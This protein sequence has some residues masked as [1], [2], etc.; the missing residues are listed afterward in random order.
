MYLVSTYVPMYG[1]HMY[2]YTSQKLRRNSEV[3]VSF[4]WARSL[5]IGGTFLGTSRTRQRPRQ[6]EPANRSF[7]TEHIPTYKANLAQ[8]TYVTREVPF[9]S[10]S[11]MLLAPACSNK[12][13]S[14][15]LA[16][17]RSQD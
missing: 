17:L 5:S 3:C 12:E 8:S 13:K 10:F 14:I 6:P 7:T 4:V 9:N 15:T 1:V 11:T 16:R 2:I